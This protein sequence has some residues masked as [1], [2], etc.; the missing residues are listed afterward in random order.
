MSMLSPPL[1]LFEEDFDAEM[2]VYIISQEKLRAFLENCASSVATSRAAEAIANLTA[3]GVSPEQD[4]FLDNQDPHFEGKSV[5]FITAA[6][7]QRTRARH[8]GQCRARTV[9][10]EGL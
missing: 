1:A 2:G 10:Y 8:V 6:A 3:S 9:I 4:R 5:F 7:M